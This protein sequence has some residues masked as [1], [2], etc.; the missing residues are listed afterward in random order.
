MR[1]G[2]CVPFAEI[3]C[4][5]VETDHGGGQ[6]RKVDFCVAVNGEV[7][8]I[9]GSHEGSDLASEGFDCD[10]PELLGGRSGMG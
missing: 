3:L 5:G 6:G 7:D 8:A 10:L 9:V 1:A 2:Y 4:G